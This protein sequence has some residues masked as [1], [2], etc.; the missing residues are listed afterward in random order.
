[1]EI[2]LNRA[3]GPPHQC[4]KPKVVATFVMADH[5]LRDWANTAPKTGY[6]KVD[7]KII[8]TDTNLNYTGRF[9]LVH[10]SV[11]FP[12]LKDHVVGFLRFMAGEACPSHMEPDRY[13]AF[14]VGQ[15]MTSERRLECLTTSNWI[16]EQP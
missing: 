6:D 8:D 3:E 12:D 16:Q 15:G 9:D 1:M 11:A 13:E 5:I 14:L 4:G 2:T 10:W 7:F